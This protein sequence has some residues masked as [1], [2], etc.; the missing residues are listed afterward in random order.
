MR[1][2]LYNNSLLD[3]SNFDTL[4]VYSET[5][6][7]QFEVPT[8]IGNKLGNKLKGW[9]VAPE[10]TKYRFHLACDD[11]CVLNMGLDQSDPLNTT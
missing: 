8:N 2:E 1:R 5:L 6:H 3:W 9:F 7:T 10:T 4:G 11:N